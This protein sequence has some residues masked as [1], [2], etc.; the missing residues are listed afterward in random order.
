MSQTS[1]ITNLLLLNTHVIGVGFRCHPL[2]TAGKVSAAK[3]TDQKCDNFG[4]TVTS[5]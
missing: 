2:V 1:D 3:V 5:F 4:L